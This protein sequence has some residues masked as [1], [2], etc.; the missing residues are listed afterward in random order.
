MPADTTPATPPQAPEPV[1]ELL[2]QAGGS[3]TR[4]PDGSLLPAAPE[5]TEPNQPE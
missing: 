3:Y 2:P 5:A 4:Q 1:A